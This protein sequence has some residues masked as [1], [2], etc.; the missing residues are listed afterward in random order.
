MTDLW[1]YLSPAAQAA[2]EFKEKGSS[3]LGR[4][5][6]VSSPEEAAKFVAEQKKRFHDATHHCWAY[7]I[8]WAEGLQERSSDGGE[9]SH[10]AGLPIASAL[11]GRGV[12]DACLVV[13]RYFGG[14]K[15]GTG[16]LARAYRTAAQ[17]VLDAADL[18]PKVLC[19]EWEIS[20][21]YGAQGTVRHAA[22][23]LGV[24]LREA[25]SAE[26]LLLS[27]SVPK[28]AAEAFESALRQ[29]SESWKGGITWRSR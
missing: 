5:A 15:L 26:E 3:F 21:P 13:I 8:G 24:R 22:S 16:G 4:L 27:A 9:P 7:R 29:A 20:L 14:V 12:S 18:R 28:G 10:T 19:A 6:P 17:L 25:G 23:R 1:S 2:S 11:E